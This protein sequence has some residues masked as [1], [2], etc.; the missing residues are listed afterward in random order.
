ME[1]LRVESLHA[2]YGKALVLRELTLHADPG[3]CIAF[4]GPNGVGKTTAIRAISGVIKPRSGSITWQGT[5][6]AGKPPHE[7][8]RLGV[9][10]VP[11]GRRLYGGMTVTENLLMG[12]YSS[13]R[14]EALERLEEIR[15]AFPLLAERGSQLAGS[16]SGGQQQLCAIARALMSSPELLLVDELSLGLSPAAIKEVLE[17]IRVAQRLFSPTIVL[18]DQDVNVAAELATR[19]YFFDLG[20]VAAEGPMEKLVEASLIKE[21]YFRKEVRIEV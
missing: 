10:V 9:A 7:I 11:E 21:L 20:A 14:G 17:G 19:G 8:V 3:E 18:V 16:F 1:G 12:A 5:S 4:L 13:S 6:L 2:G 15:S